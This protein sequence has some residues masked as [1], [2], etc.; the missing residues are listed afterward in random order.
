[1]ETTEDDGAGAPARAGFPWAGVRVLALAAAL[2]AAVFLTGLAPLPEG[3][4]YARLE[5]DHDELMAARSGPADRTLTVLF[6]GNS[7]TFRN[8]LPAMLVDLAS[9]DP[10]APVRL[11]V[12][13]VTYP[14]ATLDYMRTRTGALAWAQAHHA[15]YVV[16]QEHSLWYAAHYADALQAAGA[17]TDALRPLG[18]TPL[19]FQI[20]G[21]GDG[22][23]V[24]ANKDYAAF[25]WTPADDARNAAES[26]QR[27]G[28][29]LGL[30]VV[31]VG[32]AFEAARET[33]GAP[34]VWGPD[35]HHP[36]VAG[37]YLAALVFYRALTGRTGAAR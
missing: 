4:P 14:D 7:L 15:D 12:K 19:L 25:G 1:M 13:A 34:D 32:L 10:G 9:S 28:R 31:P 23:P 18:E 22:S 30:G 20:P 29:R 17:W 2:V 8:D 35:H 6:I 16:L 26:T 11:Q 36:S 3:A 37:T 33:K 24:Y 27:L 5:R 21:D